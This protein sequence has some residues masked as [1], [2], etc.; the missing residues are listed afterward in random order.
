[1]KL[2]LNAL[3]KYI[4]GLVLVGILLFPAAGTL[5]YPNGWLFIG[6]L[7]VPMLIFGTILFFK[8]KELLRRRLIAKEK[9]SEQKL[10]ILLSCVVYLGGF[11][12][13]GLDF[14]FGWS[15]LPLGLVIVA[16][17][18][19]LAGY[20]MFIEVSR[21][22]IWLSR[23]IEVQDGQKVVSTGLYGIVRHPM[24]TASLLLFLSL[25]IILGSL[26]S[27]FIF[28]LCIPILVLRIHGE[29]KML[30]KELD[31]YMEYRQKV[32]FRL[33]PFLW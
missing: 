18:I 28:L 12:V 19:F 33:M 1:M 25:P 15:H 23:T 26:W 8:A 5:C 22:N 11:V 32:R 4:S 6:L 16:S 31:G 14:R 3:T 17:V 2:L 20:A 27:F 9:Q 7:F 30:L 13:A 24:Y 10:V 29:E 21:E